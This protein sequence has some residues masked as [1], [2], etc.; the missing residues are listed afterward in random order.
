[1]LLDYE[2]DDIEGTFGLTFSVSYESWGE[3][4]V[5]FANLNIIIIVT[6]IVNVQTRDLVAGGSNISV[7]K[8]NR[9]VRL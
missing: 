5:S 9:K 8:S 1:M 6:V 7:T 4:K 2:G 3:V